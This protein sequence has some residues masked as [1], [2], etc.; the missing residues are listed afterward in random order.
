ML[1]V[2]FPLAFFNLMTHLIIHVV[3]ELKI[4]GPISTRWCYSVEK[5]L[6]VLKR[7]F[8][9]N[10]KPEGC[11]ASRYMYDEALGFFN[12]YF[13]WYPHTRHQMWD[14]NKEKVD[15]GEVLV[16][17]DKIKRLTQKEIKLIHELDGY[18]ITNSKVMDVAHRYVTHVIWLVSYN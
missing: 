2:W 5:Y 7:Y 18:V 4:C 14:A 8:C 16:G 9:N 1:E 10:A 3:D 11:M 15:S 17:C 12:K 13:T 6:L